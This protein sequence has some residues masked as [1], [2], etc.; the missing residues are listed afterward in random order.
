MAKSVDVA[1]SATSPI[2]TDQLERVREFTREPILL[3]GEAIED[4]A[5][6]TARHRAVDAAL[7]ELDAGRE[8]P[9]PEW[10]RR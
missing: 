6:G 2:T 7:A 1:E 8:A 4:I 5:P 10:R 3:D 9:S